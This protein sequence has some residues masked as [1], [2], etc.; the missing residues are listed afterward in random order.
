MTDIRDLS[1]PKPRNHSAHGKGEEYINEHLTCSHVP[2]NEGGYQFD[3]YLLD[4]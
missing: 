3:I 2:Y 1:P 4:P